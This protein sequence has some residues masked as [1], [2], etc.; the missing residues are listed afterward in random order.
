MS[1]DALTA[2]PLSDVDL[3]WLVARLD[4]PGDHVELL[5]AL[6]AGEPR[7]RR[8]ALVH[9]AARAEERRS[10][11]ELEALAALIPA[12]LDGPEEDRTL[13]AEIHWRLARWTANRALPRWREAMQSPA[14]V[15]AW[16]RTAI[17]VDPTVLRDEPGSEGLYQSLADVDAVEVSAPDVLIAELAAHPDP[18]VQMRALQRIQRDLRVGAILPSEA[19]RALAGLLG[20]SAKAVVAAALRELAEPW[21]RVLPPPLALKKPRRREDPRVAAAAIAC[22]ASFGDTERLVAWASDGEAATTL[23]QQALRALGAVA[24]REHLDLIFALGAADPLL[25]GAAAIE[26]LRVLHRRGELVAPAHADPLLQIYLGDCSLSA[27]EI[28]PIAFTC[29]QALL[30]VIASAAA[31]DPTWERRLLLLVALAR[32]PQ[33]SKPLPIAAI[34]VAKLAELGDRGDARSF[35]RALGRVGTDAEEAVVLAWIDREPAAALDALTA[36]GGAATVAALA[37]RLGL[38]DGGLDVAPALRADRAR[39]LELVWHLGDDGDRARVLAVL[40][41]RAIPAAITADLGKRPDPR[42]LSLLQHAL[43]AV[44]ASPA[45]Y[46]VALANTGAASLLPAISD[47]LLALMTGLD[48]GEI[49]NLPEFPD[50]RKSRDDKRTVPVGV[51]HAIRDLG[52]ALHARRAIRPRCLVDAKSAAEAGEALLVDLILGLLGR[53]DLADGE[54]AILLT[55]LLGLASPR[56]FPAIHRL[57][58]HRSP[59]VR[60]VVIALLAKAGADELSTSLRLLTG[61]GDIETSRQAILALASLGAPWSASAIAEALDH[62]NMNLKKAAAEALRTSGAP[63]VVPKLLF[64]L[65]RHDNPG[66]RAHLEGALAAILGEA[67]VATLFAAI[68]AEASEGEASERRRELLLSALSGRIT[69]RAARGAVERGASFA[70][71]LLDRL[72]AGEI[73][74][75]S[76]GLHALAVELDALGLA[77]RPALAKAPEPSLSRE[78]EALQEHGWDDA[79]ARALAARAATEPLSSEEIVIARRTLPEWIELAA[80]ADEPTRS[81]ALQ[82]IAQ[83]G[84]NALTADEVLL[85][86]DRVRVL[87]EGLR[88]ATDER[89][90]GLLDLIMKLAPA[91]LVPGRI[92]AAFQLRRVD[93]PPDRWD[94][95][96][97]ELLRRVGASIT[98]ADLDRAL[99]ECR[100]APNGWEIEA[101]S[102]R[103]AFGIAE[104]SDDAALVTALL[105]ALPDPEAL[106]TLRDRMDAGSRA[107]LRALIEVFPKAPSTQHALVL[108]WMEALQPLGAAPWVIAEQAAEQR[109]VDERSPR[110]DREPARSAAVRERLVAQ[111]DAGRSEERR[112]AA[113][114]LLTWPEPDVH[115]LVLRAWLRGA[116]DRDLAPSPRLAAPLRA[117]PIEEIHAWSTDDAECERLARVLAELDRDDLRRLLPTLLAIWDDGSLRAQRAV[118]PVIRRIDAEHVLTAILPRLAHGAFGQLELIGGPVVTTPALEALLS[119]ARAEAPA[120]VSALSFVPGPLRT[121]ERARDDEQRL[122]AL[123]ERRAP[124]TPT[125]A[126]SRADLLEKARGGDPEVVRLALSA[127]ARAPDEEVVAL[128]LAKIADRS[129][130]VRLHAHRLLRGAGERDDYLRASVLLLD[131][132]LPDVQRAAVRVVTFAGHLAALPAV[133]ELLRAPH[134][135]VQRAAAEGLVHVGAAAIPAL[136]KALQRARPDR[137]AALEE[138]LARIEQIEKKSGGPE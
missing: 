132:P 74:L 39:A 86:V 65:G 129:P 124:L 127:L 57:L 80:T 91:L 84:L 88:D 51:L 117:L 13:L 38:V 72:F 134:P 46:L 121:K 99:A 50:E 19:Q 21:S 29:R 47:L 22:A 123:R 32:G 9:L 97:L 70:P 115:L 81:G 49:E 69:V 68:E 16:R 28:A 95:S 62:A 44:D 78:A 125:K 12:D 89:R 59:H 5:R 37:T 102:L 33:G 98:R 30:D 82:I 137:R 61:A 122:S 15:V 87:L 55:P 90:S 63:E 113:T 106:A 48:R 120:W 23:R 2:R 107:T 112:A 130:R 14:V 7:L 108:D 1:A 71:R 36:I 96:R 27:A 104:R 66:L 53:S 133:V 110:I 136:R 111:L 116:I 52:R 17:L 26:A 18:I 35:L 40:D 77:W 73:K 8:L 67:L 109:V 94:H 11:G 42:E 4:R 34:L 41:P 25:F 10:R 43:G 64:W 135:P 58:R 128:L 31:H 54:T 76:G 92:E 101:W 114:T 6:L 83:I 93:L 45:D 75:V 131:D 105:T 56:I 100:R 24:T 3:P 79:V 60:K 119:R 138:V 20:A 118:A 103:V 85:L 126:E